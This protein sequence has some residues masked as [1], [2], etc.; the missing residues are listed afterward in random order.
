[1]RWHISA[2]QIDPRGRPASS[3]VGLVLAVVN[4]PASVGSQHALLHLMPGLTDKARLPSQ[5][6][7][8]RSERLAGNSTDNLRKTSL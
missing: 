7:R 5:L 8:A 2:N 4:E 6:G 1:M 3:I